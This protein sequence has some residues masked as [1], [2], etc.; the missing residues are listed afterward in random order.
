[1]TLPLLQLAVLVYL[2][3]LIG[4]HRK[5]WQLLLYVWG[6]FGFAYL[7]IHLSLLQEWNVALATL[8][9]RHLQAIMAPAG[10]AL[11]FVD[12]TTLLVPDPTGWSG[13]RIG[14]ECSTLIELS[15]FTGLMLFYPRL[16]LEKRWKYLASGFIGT[17][18]LNLIRLVIITVIIATWGKPTVPIAHAVVGRL[19]YF[20]GVVA[21]YWFLLTRPTLA[22]V[23]RSIEAT[24]RA[25]R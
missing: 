13:M 8:E 14:V 4:I 1:M 9:A 11:T 16:S 25:V 24:G 18:V 3:G 15:V 5:G 22:L 2:L 12:D 7:L 6:A 17:Y 19:V 20:A 21:L 23:H 10:V